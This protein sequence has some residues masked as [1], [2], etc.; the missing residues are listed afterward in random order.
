[1]QVRITS[2]FSRSRKPSGPTA[3]VSP[4]P[5]RLQILLAFAAIYLIWGTTFLGIALVLRSLPPFASASLRFLIAGSLLLIW[6]RLRDPRPLAGL[7]LPRVAL[8]G[9]LLLSGGNGLVVW[10]QQGV[11]SGVAALVIASMPVAVLVL[12][13]AF[14]GH[15][16]PQW[17]A[18]AGIAIGLCGVLLIVSQI[19][20]LAGAVR[21]LHVISLLGAVFAWALGTLLHRGVPLN[22]VMASAG[23][24]M[25]VGGAVLGLMALPGGEWTRLDLAR[26]SLTSLAALAYLIVFGSIVAQGSYLWLLG[27]VAPQKVA[28]YA[29]VNPVV[30]MALG[31]L[32]LNERLNA[33]AGLAVLLVLVGVALV[34]WPAGTRARS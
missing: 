11:P 13:R 16:L 26:V 23:V 34:L 31:A 7:P 21:P 27:H 29:L 5:T 22:R 18:L 1:M 10:A 20:R 25:L 3:I 24:Q 8:C 2:I 12:Q 6:L 32:V 15:R 19:G 30:A 4:A 9:V 33:L 17:R 28:T 14:F